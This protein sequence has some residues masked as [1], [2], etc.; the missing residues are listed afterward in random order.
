[1]RAFLAAVLIAPLLAI[2]GFSAPAA[3]DT[4]ARL[5]WTSPGTEAAFA[6]EWTAVLSTAMVYEG[7]QQPLQAGFGTVDVYMDGGAAPW[8][9]ALPIQTDGSVFV[10][11]QTNQPLLAPGVHQLTA[12]FTPV[13]N[14]PVGSATSGTAFALTITDLAASASVELDTDGPQPLIT[15]HLSGAYLD[16]MVASFLAHKSEVPPPGYE[17]REAERRLALTPLAEAR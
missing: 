14:S 17:H 15:T 9:V 10:S 12:V 2:V 7:G 1:M 16:A 8:A 4:V 13:G 3:A 11:Q 5:E 6:G